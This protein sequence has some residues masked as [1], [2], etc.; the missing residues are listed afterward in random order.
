MSPQLQRTQSSTQ[1]QNAVIKDTTQ[2]AVKSTQSKDCSNIA[3]G[4][5]QFIATYFSYKVDCIF[6]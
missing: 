6:D 1:K 5:F 2:S 4:R 3:E